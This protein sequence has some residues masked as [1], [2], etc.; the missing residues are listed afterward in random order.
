L[1]AGIGSRKG[2]LEILKGNKYFLSCS[3]MKPY[4]SMTPGMSHL[5]IDPQLL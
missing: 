2:V 3:T 1:W 4:H 5:A